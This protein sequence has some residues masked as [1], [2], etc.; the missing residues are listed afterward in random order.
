MLASPSEGTGYVRCRG[1][2]EGV[3]DERGGGLGRLRWR[4]RGA[5]LW[6]LFGL[7]TV[8][9]GAIMHW[10]PIAGAGTRW[11]PAL[12][13]AGCLNIAAV[14][15]L[16]GLGGL[17][18]RRARPSLPKVVAD[19]YAGS[20]VLAVLALTF[21]TAGLVH[22]PELSTERDAFREQSFAV[23]RWVISHG[24][25]F[26][27]AH[28]GLADSLRIDRDLYRTCIPTPDPRR[29]LCLIVDTSAS[30]PGVS[31]DDSREPNAS[32]NSRGGFR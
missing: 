30:P 28:V 14:A 7:I 26:A 4:L 2:S 21:V 32:L 15:L 16:G 25:A 31:R 23:R 18:L 5:L 20:I 13:L 10:L 24:D 17:A 27:Q 12:L 8:F 19:D 6:P 11:V 3:G 1:M 22:R 29:D 9:D